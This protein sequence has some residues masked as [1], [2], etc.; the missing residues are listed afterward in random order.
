MY[1]EILLGQCHVLIHLKRRHKQRTATEWT[2]IV[3]LESIVEIADFAQIVQELVDAR[4]V[5]FDERIEGHHI[6]FLGIRRLVRQV[7]KH[8]RYLL[9]VSKRRT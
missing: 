3:Y 6:L 8:L 7:L 5:I 9:D 2:I 1:H 4:L